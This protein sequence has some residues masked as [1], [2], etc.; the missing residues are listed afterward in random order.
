MN[1]PREF[2]IKEN[3]YPEFNLNNFF[4]SFAKIDLG[5]FI[6]SLLVGAN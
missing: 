4:H 6:K 5:I 3:W 2:K 1:I